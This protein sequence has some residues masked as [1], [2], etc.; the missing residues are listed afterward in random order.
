MRILSPEDGCWEVDHTESR[1]DIGR[2]PEAGLRLPYKSVSRRHARILREEGSYF[3]EDLS[4]CGGTQI[5]C[6]VIPS[7][8]LIMLRHLDSIQ[9]SRVI[10]QFRR[11]ER[12]VSNGQQ[13]MQFSRNPCG[14]QLR[15]RSIHCRPGAV[16]GIRYSVLVILCW[17]VQR[18]RSFVADG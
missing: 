2:A 18:R 17:W 9:V 5:N 14:V 7:Q 15:V 12:H 4:S 3:L 16:F 10:M 1:T 11:D 6:K 13:H 8:Q